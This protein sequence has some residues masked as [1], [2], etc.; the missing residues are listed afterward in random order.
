MPEIGEYATWEALIRAEAA[1]GYP[2]RS[3]LACL[4]L[5][6]FA[7]NSFSAYELSTL[8]TVN[9]IGQCKA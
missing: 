7:F 1:Y 6:S 8:W 4:S 9:M 5:Y 2:L 3:Y